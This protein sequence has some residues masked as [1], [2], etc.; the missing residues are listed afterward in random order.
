MVREVIKHLDDSLTS[1]MSS[2]F[3]VL[4]SSKFC[5]LKTGK[6]PSVLLNQH[7]S[8]G[9]LRARNTDC[10]G[11][12][13]IRVDGPGTHPPTVGTLALV[14]GAL[15]LRNTNNAALLFADSKVSMS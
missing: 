6:S 3:V 8:L 7:L 10:G 1:K 2:K 4:F 11:S 14:P 15:V 13:L 12:I 5:L 9:V